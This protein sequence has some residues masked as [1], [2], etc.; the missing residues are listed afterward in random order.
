MPKNNKTSPLHVAVKRKYKQAVVLLLSL[1]ANVNNTD[2]KGN[3]PLHYGVFFYDITKMFLERGAR[4]NAL[5]NDGNSPLLTLTEACVFRD[6]KKTFGLLLSY[7]ANIKQRNK[8]GLTVLHHAI[9]VCDIDIIQYLIEKGAP[10]DVKSRD[11]KTPLSIAL[12]NK[13]YGYG[14]QY[15]SAD[16]WDIIINALLKHSR[17]IQI[18]TDQYN[19]FIRTKLDLSY[20]PIRNIFE[21]ILRTQLQQVQGSVVKLAKL[22]GAALSTQDFKYTD[23]II[24]IFKNSQTLSIQEGEGPKS[25]R[26]LDML[27]IEPN[28]FF[29]YGEKMC[30]IFENQHVRLTDA[31]H[32]FH[33][34][35][36]IVSGCSNRSKLF[37]TSTKLKNIVD[38]LQSKGFDINEPINIDNA[39]Y[40]TKQTP[41]SLLEIYINRYIP[42]R[43]K[44]ANMLQNLHTIMVSRGA[45]TSTGRRSIRQRQRGTGRK[46]MKYYISEWTSS[47]YRTIQDARR[48]GMNSSKKDKNV[49]RY[50]FQEFR[51]SG[52]RSPVI[53]REFTIQYDKNKVQRN[54]RPTYLY[55][56]IHGELAK[57]LLEKKK[58]QDKG[59]IAFSRHK[60]IAEI[61]AIKDRPGFVMRLKLD[62]IKKGT[63]WIWFRPKR[64]RQ[65][66]QKIER[67]IHISNIDEAEVL[68]PPGTL[69]LNSPLQNVNWNIQTPTIDVTYIPDKEATNLSQK[70]KMYRTVKTNRNSTKE[71][72]DATSWFSKLFNSTPKGRKQKRKRV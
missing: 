8:K 39:G 29:D 9:K 26:L 43:S 47:R 69:V 67:N 40:S 41:I 63:P 3:T 5:N 38:Y 14:S 42:I 11:G 28:F 23:S 24:R 17:T 50:I 70:K 68:L 1:G 57:L 72:Q 21:R 54:A 16:Q 71:E 18:N 27:Y 31:L 20:K 35:V 33:V 48:K 55:R 13:M 64:L 25:K 22:F 19:A 12:T 30:H 45:R 36:R 37:N 34:L 61:F 2:S 4:V 44:N 51:N 15:R 6:I 66:K 7:G 53:P 10:V 56:G 46:N 32:P 49:N 62:S 60:E 52:T 65:K 59:F 58:M